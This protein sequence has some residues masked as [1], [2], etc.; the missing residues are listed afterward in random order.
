MPA[1]F[2]LG[3]R[4]EDVQPQREGAFV[5]QLVLTEP[6]GVETILYI[7]TGEQTLLSLVPGLTDLH[8]G[9][10]VRFNIIRERLHYFRSNGTRIPV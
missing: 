6:L 8:I 3:I 2:L 7:K 9:E 5:G 1:T 10:E 4:P